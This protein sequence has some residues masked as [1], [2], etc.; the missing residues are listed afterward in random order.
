MLIGYL[1][2]VLTLQE[3]LNP[4]SV[5]MFLLINYCIIALIFKTSVS[6]ISVTFRLPIYVFFNTN[7]ILPIKVLPRSGKLPQKHMY[8]YVL[9]YI[10]IYMCTFIIVTDSI[11][12]SY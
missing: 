2:Q 1:V 6:I 11:F 9:V 5:N 12:P 8:I 3:V 10:V 7:V 4:S